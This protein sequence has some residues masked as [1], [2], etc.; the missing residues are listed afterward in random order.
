MT[1]VPFGAHTAWLS[2]STIGWPL[3]VTRI[4]ATV[5]SPVTHGIGLVPVTKGQP[6]IAYGADISTVGWPPTSTR[7][8]GMVG[9]AVPP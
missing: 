5:H 7:E 3:D 8:F 4:A 2:I 9:V 6:A 1:G